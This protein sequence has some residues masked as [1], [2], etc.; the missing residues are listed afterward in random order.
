MSRVLQTVAPVL[1]LLLVVAIVAAWVEANAKRIH[2]ESAP[3]PAQSLSKSAPAPG[4][5]PLRRAETPAN[6]QPAPNAG[7]CT[8]KFDRRNVQRVAPTR[9]PV[10]E[11]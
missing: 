7:D 6:V 10:I 1:K 5:D 4:F 3:P 11:T 8:P 2:P 9:A